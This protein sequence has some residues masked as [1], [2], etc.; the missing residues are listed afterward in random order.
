MYNSKATGD[1]YT[2]TIANETTLIGCSVHAY[3]NEVVL[4][5]PEGVKEIAGYALQGCSGIKKI[6]LPNSLR[7][8]GQAAFISCTDLES[9]YIPDTVR[10][11]GV[12]VFRNCPKLKRVHVPPE[13]MNKATANDRGLPSYMW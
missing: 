1:E 3:G 11:I 2:L 5:V 6:V 12:G 10:E 4:K 7:K 13:I 8:I 9:V